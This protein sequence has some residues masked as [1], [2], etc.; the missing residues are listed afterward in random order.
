MR[1]CG[2]A[3]IH[4]RLILI[5][6]RGHGASDKP[7]DPVAYA[8]DQRVADVIAVL[9]QLSVAKALFWGYSMGGWIGF[10]VA[11]YAKERV[12]ALVI[13][14]QHPYARSAEPL[15]QMIRRGIAQ[16]GEA[17]VSGMEEMYGPES[18]A[19]KGRL[20]SAD[21]EALLALAQDRP[22]LE[23][24]L[25]TMLIPCCLYAGQKDPI[26]TEVEECS[27]H[28]PRATFFSLPGLSHCEA[29]ARS[30]LVL[31]RVARFLKAADMS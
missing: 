23:G 25:P 7:P 3:K 12:R 8:L 31:P 9:D 4:Y 5:D 21:L 11:K 22:S 20:L 19:R 1:V 18:P 13:G 16:G 15:R 2:S 29:F 6:A 17:F 30:E 10:G 14:G 28:M 24:I 27:R 26:Y